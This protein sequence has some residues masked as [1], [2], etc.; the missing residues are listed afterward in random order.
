M[1]QHPHQR[2]QIEGSGGTIVKV[3]IDW[4]SNVFGRILIAG[5]VTVSKRD[6]IIHEVENCLMVFFQDGH[7]RSVYALQNEENFW[8]HQNLDQYRDYIG[9]SKLYSRFK[10]YRKRPFN[11]RTS[12]VIFTDMK[13]KCVFVSQTKRVCFT[14][15]ENMR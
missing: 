7:N 5:K 6:V 2:N 11:V 1:L 8:C 15:R 10:I 12:H 3:Q 4:F 13:S 9:F 14:F